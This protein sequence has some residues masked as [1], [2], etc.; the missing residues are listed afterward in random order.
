L[1]K[2]GEGILGVK[3]PMSPSINFLTYF[4]GFAG[5]GVWYPL[6]SIC[7]LPFEALLEWPTTRLY[8]DC[9]LDTCIFN[10][11]TSESWTQ[12]YLWCKV[13]EKRSNPSFGF[14]WI[15]F[16]LSQIILHGVFPIVSRSPPMLNW[17]VGTF[18]AITMLCNWSCVLL[19]TV[20]VMKV[21]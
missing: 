20:I 19:S 5:V 13:C 16:R 1:I 2:K 18:V 14:H 10:N 15:D 3:L 11:V 4:Q 17:L 21:S 8:N 6:P 9:S 12:T 7:K